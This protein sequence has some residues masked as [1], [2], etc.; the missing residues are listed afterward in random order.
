MRKKSCEMR[1][2][3]A[4]KVARKRRLE[5][6]ADGL[7]GSIGQ[8]NSANLSRSRTCREPAI[9]MGCSRSVE[10]QSPGIGAKLSVPRGISSVMST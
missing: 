3:L 2:F 10:T 5:A 4:P 1:A 6:R 7:A 9:G 8:A